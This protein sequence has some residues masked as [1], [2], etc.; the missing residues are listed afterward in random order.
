MSRGG[1]SGGFRGSSIGGDVGGSVPSP[2]VAA[3]MQNQ[4]VSISGLPTTPNRANSQA[5]PSVFVDNE[6]AA[7]AAMDG[8]YV[9]AN[10]GAAATT[11]NGVHDAANNGAPGVTSQPISPHV[12]REIADMSL[13]HYGGDP[14]P[15]SLPGTPRMDAP[16][17]LTPPPGKLVMN[18]VCLFLSWF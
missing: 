7:T 2:E 3:S 1:I 16:K 15:Y 18:F 4:S 11:N 13:L 17:S 10:N 12:T 8:A 9:A 14:P 6:N 5:A